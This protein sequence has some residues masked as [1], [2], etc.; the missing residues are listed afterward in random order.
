[1]TGVRTWIA[2][3]A[4][5]A[6][7]CGVGDDAAEVT[8]AC[9]GDSNTCFRKPGE[10][11]D[12]KSWCRYW[13][14]SL[15]PLCR[16]EQPVE[17]EVVNLA[18]G[19]ATACDNPAFPNEDLA[20]DEPWAQ[21]QYAAARDELGAELVIASFGTNDVHL[22]GLPPAQVVSC[23]ERLWRRA[24]ADGVHIL[25]ALAPPTFE[26]W[27]D[28]EPINDDLAAL[29]RQLR[30][31]FPDEHLVDFATGFEK[32]RYFL[33]NDPLHFNDAGQRLRAERVA[34]AVAASGAWDALGLTR[35]GS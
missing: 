5:A 16:E 32:A 7:S 31:T 17:V 8:I 26:A 9:L 27:D 29:D 11:D 19:G 4:L 23:Y 34:A 15:P 18:V 21:V 35:C 28:G 1:M 10:C 2:A 3:L 6:T 30:E 25:L 20:R 12:V 14:E 24:R 22:L 13:A 33:P